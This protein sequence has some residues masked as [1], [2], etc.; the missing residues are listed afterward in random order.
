MLTE[1]IYLHRHVNVSGP[2][3]IILLGLTSVVGNLL[4]VF[5]YRDTIKKPKYCESDDVHK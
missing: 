3:S 1:K 4:Q 5:I 2:Q